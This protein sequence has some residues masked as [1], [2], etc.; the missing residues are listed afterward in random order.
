MYRLYP[1]DREEIIRILEERVR[2]L[3]STEHH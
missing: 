1:R 3:I 2:K